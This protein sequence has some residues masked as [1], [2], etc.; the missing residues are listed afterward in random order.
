MIARPLALVI[1]SSLIIDVPMATAQE[2][3][4][5]ERPSSA[6]VDVSDYANPK[7]M[8][9][10]LTGGFD[11]LERIGRSNGERLRIRGYLVG[12]FD[13]VA[14]LVSS[15]STSPRT[16]N[17]CKALSTAFSD[18]HQYLKEWLRNYV[19][20]Y[21]L[22]ILQSATRSGVLAEMGVTSAVAEFADL[23]LMVDDG[24]TDGARLI[25]TLD[26]CE[27]PVLDS[28]VT[29]TGYVRHKLPSSAD[30]YVPTMPSASDLQSLA[31]YYSIRGS[32][33]VTG[34]TVAAG[35]N[36]LT[37][38]DSRGRT[39]ELRPS[40]DQMF[41]IE[42]PTQGQVTFNPQRH[43]LTFRLGEVVF[44]GTRADAPVDFGSPAARH[45]MLTGEYRVITSP[46]L[47]RQ[48][49]VASVRDAVLTV[50]ANDGNLLLT[51]AQGRQ[52]RLQPT[53]PDAFVISGT[54]VI[55]RFVLGRR[56]VTLQYREGNERFSATRPQ[57][58]ETPRR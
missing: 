31:G 18:H 51:D 38:T 15:S 43:A 49:T 57:S 42:G 30:A 28:I 12:L 55:I 22:R 40:G 2:R 20:G 44:T 46:S 23:K 53:G 45:Q 19:E 3:R 50:A 21:N 35:K 32:S 14:P 4:V 48:R 11:E 13:S 36:Q 26:G 47:K 7:F 29:S 8:Q 10:L 16:P 1:L 9:M 39:Y 34:V 37:M 54:E 56:E 52:H 5:R 24:K 33:S 6:A 25:K 41:A 27:T 58:R 17:A